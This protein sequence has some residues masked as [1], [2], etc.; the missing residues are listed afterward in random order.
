MRSLVVSLSEYTDK[1]EQGSIDT[2]RDLASWA[3][4]HFKTD[5][6]IYM[7]LKMN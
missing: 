7:Y 5:T 1:I 3:A 4:Y 2:W 6:N